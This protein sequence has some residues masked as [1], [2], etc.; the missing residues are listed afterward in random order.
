MVGWGTFVRGFF[1]WGAGLCLTSAA[2][3]AE[4]LFAGRPRIE[5]SGSFK[6]ILQIQQLNHQN[7]FSRS[8]G[9]AAE[10]RLRLE[11]AFV[12]GPLRI[13]LANQTEIT[14]Q[15]PLNPAFPL[16][17]PIPRP[18]WDTR[19]T[20]ADGSSFKAVT[21]LDRANVKWNQG[22][23]SLIAGKQVVALGVGHLFT[24]V[25]QTAR[26]PFVI[27]DPEY[28]IPEDAVTLQWD[29]ALAIEARFLPKNPGQ[30]SDNFHFRA[31]GTKYGYDL[32]LTAGRS[33]DKSFVAIETAGNLGEALVRGEFTLY[34]KAGTTV[35][36][37]L[38]GIDYAFDAKWSAEAEIFYAG[39]LVHRSSPYRGLW[40]FGTR[41]KYD[42]SER[43]KLS[44][45]AIANLNDKSVLAQVNAFYS[46]ST[47]LELG[48]GQFLGLGSS[49]SEFAGTVPFSPTIS[50]GLPNLTYALVR[51][52][53]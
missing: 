45:F 19:W 33:D 16:P 2:G 47:N 6:S 3:F 4:G 37:G 42:L 40:Y 10:E 23:F 41:V 24:A 49:T 17:D 28:P 22:G 36:Q 43:W 46:L 21:R 14:A 35:G 31:K 13:E 30:R 5:K 15:T 7:F 11:G 34:D 20:I 39:A 52:Y 1:L 8:T 50:L 38:G 9:L 26:Q 29:G 12:W 32:A 51:Y 27:V 48:L 53:F 25:S 44:M 18:K